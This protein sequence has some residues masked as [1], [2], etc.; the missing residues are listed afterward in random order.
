[1][2]H[3]RLLQTVVC[4]GLVALSLAGC[5]GAQVEP[6]TTPASVSPTAIET[7]TPFPPTPTPIPPTPTPAMRLDGKRVLFV[8]YERFQESEYSVP[9]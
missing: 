4:L 3:Q 5:A 6:T 7:L 9:R 8:I 2:N 1:M